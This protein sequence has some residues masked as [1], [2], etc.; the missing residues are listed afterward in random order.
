M[1]ELPKHL[2]THDLWNV[3]ATQYDLAAVGED[4]MNINIIALAACFSEVVDQ[5]IRQV[6]IIDHD[7]PCIHYLSG[8]LTADKLKV[9]ILNQ[10]YF[11]YLNNV[12]IHF[13]IQFRDLGHQITFF[14]AIVI[15]E[16]SFELLERAIT[17]ELYQLLE[18]I[19]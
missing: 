8:L 6:K 12:R 19:F 15:L 11:L 14:I 13:F 10:V 7:L 1:A 18:V 5:K 2:G 16:T 3:I 17:A 9:A 4:L